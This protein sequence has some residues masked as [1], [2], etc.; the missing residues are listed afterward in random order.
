MIRK[1][2]VALRSEELW[3]LKDQLEPGFALH[4][5]TD[6]PPDTQMLVS[7]AMP[8]PADLLDHLPRLG[9]VAIV[10][11]GYDG[12]DRKW[13]ANRG[14]MLANTPEVN[15]PDV[16][17]LAVTMGLTIA[18]DLLRNDALLRDTAD[19]IPGRL[20][21]TR[22]VR[23]LTAGIVGMGAIGQETARRLHAFG[24]QILWWGPREKSG[25]PWPRCADVESLARASDMLIL[26][27]RHPETDP[28]LVDRAI[29][30][31]LGPDGILV[32][33]ARGSCIDEDALIEALR[34][35]RIAGAGLDVFQQEPPPVDKWGDVPRLIMSP[36]VGGY[37]SLSL[38]GTAERLIANLTAFAEGREPPYRVS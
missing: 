19:A 13:L 38:R 11:T 12:I 29:L 25:V 26:C 33:V 37:T 7:R 17:D 8:L 28:P 15:A 20:R 6:A 22:S 24:V 32:N 35:D 10:G 36:H 23:S 14:I 30:D 34:E 2:A 9:L 18:R 1:A 27:G 31:A 21:F 16:A 5:L 3:L 4:S